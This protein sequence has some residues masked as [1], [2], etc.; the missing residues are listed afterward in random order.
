[1]SSKAQSGQHCSTHFPSVVKASAYDANYLFPK[2]REHDLRECS[3][4]FDLNETNPLMEALN[5][6]KE[7]WT[8]LYKD[9]P[10]AMFGVAD[11]GG[12]G[13]GAPYLLGTEELPKIA[14]RFLRHCPE[15][16][17]KMHSH[18]EIL[19]NFVL[20]ENK[21]AIR[22]LKWLGFK[23]IEKRKYGRNQE[24]FYSFMRINKNV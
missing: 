16:I 12:N 10:I 22:W 5:D 7:A 8:I 15:Y 11:Y 6:S 9:K 13:W 24:L 19:S 4:V 1:M 20:A 21:I 17:T 23:I 3:A 2:L 14:F 18:Y